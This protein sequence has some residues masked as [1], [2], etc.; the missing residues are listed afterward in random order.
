[1]S[2]FTPSP[3]RAIVRQSISIA[4]A[5]LPFGVAFGVTADR[6][7]LSLAETMGFSALVFTGGAQFAAVSVLG[8]GG[9]VAAAVVAG[10]LLNLRLLAFG[11]V[12]ARVLVGPLWSRLLLSQLVIDETTA[13]ATG[14][15]DRDH[16][17]FGYLVCGITLF[18]LWNLATVAGFSVL[19]GADDVIETAGID[20]TI[21][22]AFLALLWP[23]LAEVDQRRAALA[24]AAVALVL[25]PFAA[26]GL[27]VIAAAVA[28]PLVL[29]AGTRR[30]T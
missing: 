18:V 22:A 4:L 3:R 1:M 8:D 28:A 5:V 17:R 10:V 13:V 16:A 20:V 19:G 11:V 26:P 15:D 30:A 12:L 7:G 24:G 2:P 9:N 29:A 14:Q 27:P 21:P 6:A 25:T 23:R